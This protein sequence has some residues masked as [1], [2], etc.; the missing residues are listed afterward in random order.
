[1]VIA[2]LTHVAE[3]WLGLPPETRRHADILLI[4]VPVRSLETMYQAAAGAD[5]KLQK[6]YQP[7]V[8]YV[9][10]SRFSLR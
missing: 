4:G 1:M 10:A 7:S 3:K 9:V 2:K 6:K 5:L 8:S